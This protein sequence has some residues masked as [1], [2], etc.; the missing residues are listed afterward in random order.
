MF[1]PFARS[2]PTRKWHCITPAISIDMK[3]SRVNSSLSEE[4]SRPDSRRP[5]CRIFERHLW[6]STG[7][8]TFGL[9]SCSIAMFGVDIHDL[10]LLLGVCI[11]AQN[12]DS[13]SPNSMH[14]QQGDYASFR[15]HEKI[16]AST[17]PP[18]V[19]FSPTSADPYVS[20]AANCFAYPPNRKTVI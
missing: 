4:S 15:V 19:F 12:E 17:L 6:R 16:L 18:F 13:V 8:R 20:F 2:A 1:S 7:A 9:Y 14:N 5:K 3:E 11:A 10:S